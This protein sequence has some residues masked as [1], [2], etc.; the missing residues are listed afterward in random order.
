VPERRQVPEG[1]P[2]GP[3]A[4]LV[5]H[6]PLGSLDDVRSIVLVEGVSD[7]IAVETLA[8]RRGVDLAAKRVLVAVLGG[9]QGTARMLQ[10]LPRRAGTTLSGLY[11]EAD[12]DVVRAAL[13]AHE[14]M[15]PHGRLEDAGFFA[16]REDLEDELIRACGADR[17]EACLE[18]EGDLTAFRRLQGQPQWREHPREAQLR[19]WIASGARRKL[20]YARLLVEAADDERL[21]LPL[22]SVLDRAAGD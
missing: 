19:R 16:C 10:L 5:A 20:R 21:P 18:T 12:A 15:P 9:V 1:Y 6:E 22:I 7:R 13:V 14:D 4:A 2:S 8:R 11:D 17:V 3:A